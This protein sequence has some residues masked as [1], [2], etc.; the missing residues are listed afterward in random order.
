M[1]TEERKC[2]AAGAYSF[3]GTLQWHSHHIASHRDI[4]GRFQAMHQLQQHGCAVHAV[5]LQS[6]ISVTTSC[7]THGSIIVR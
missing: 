4:T 3:D 1:R 7:S 5:P 6:W 2:L